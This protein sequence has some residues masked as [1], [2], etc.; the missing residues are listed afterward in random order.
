MRGPLR[1]LAAVL[2]AVLLPLALA[3]QTP[4]LS[5]VVLDA[6]TGDP[7]PGA[8][9][10]VWPAGT[11][12]T[13]LDG[14]FRLA[15]PA[16]EPGLDCRAQV[17]AVG[18]RIALVVWPAGEDLQLPK[19]IV[20]QPLAVEIGQAATV[21]AERE[22][23][24]GGAALGR[25]SLKAE[26][27]AR[28]PALLGE[29][30]ILKSLQL[31]PGIQSSGEGNSGFYIRGGGPDQN[32]LLL[33]GAPVY[34]PAHLF[35]F[36]SVFNADAVEAVDVTKGIPSAALGGRVSGFL[37][38]AMRAAES[39][40][41]R[42]EG[43]I[44]LISSRALVEGPIVPG[45]SGLLVAAR[46]TYVDALIRPFLR[47]G[48]FAGSGYFFHDLNLKAD[49]KLSDRDRLELT[50]YTG[51]DVFSFASG[52]AD[53][54]A[55]IPWGNSTASLV[56]KH[57]VGDRW[58]L[59]TTAA[60]T[61]YD[62]A[63]EADQ[64]LFRLALRSGIREGALRSA[65]TL[66]LRPGLTVQAGAE[67]IRRRFLPTEFEASSGEVD[68]DTGTA[69]PLHGLEGAAYLAADADFGPALRLAAGLRRSG[70]AHIGPFERYGT[71]YAAG[72][73]IARYGGWEPRLSARLRTG[74]RTSVKAGWGRTY[75][76]VH[77]ASLS[78]TSLPA[79]LWL[80]CTDLLA[81]Q[82]GDQL[83]AGFF[84]LLGP[85]DA[86]E[87]SVEAYAKDLRNLVEYRENVRPEDNI[88][89]P[90]DQN[91]IQGSG[92]SRGLETFLKRRSGPLTGW[93]G[94]TWSKTDRT[95]DALNGGNPFPARYDRRHDAS[96]VLQWSPSP[97]WD[98]GLTW[99]YATGNA[100]TLPVA[101]YLFEGRVTD[102]YGPRNGYRMA[103]YHRLDL[104]ATLHPSPRSS[105]TFG[106]Y[107]AYNRLNP[108]FIY[109]GNSGDPATG[110]LDIAAYQVS[111]FPVLPSV[112]YNFRF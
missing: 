93:I 70:F 101:R 89:V 96:F 11:A 68:F 10:Q 39:D 61:A 82:R 9:V 34:N 71:P 110:T 20:L 80:P 51:R 12:A 95:F 90:V 105:W 81:P 19:R 83:T 100:I 58:F 24:L 50:G 1:T 49:L 107:N 27:I 108:Y 3:G 4:T 76:Y 67:G 103:P 66:Y 79:D 22:A 57:T 91:L 54:A 30:D 64:D 109:F 37:D 62:F 21:E 29:V 43:G 65:L 35:G 40:R 41:F 94:Y 87:F 111:L 88:G 8:V 13:D 42:G 106:V 28:L 45:R 104:A 47:D 98:F 48:A 17:S 14:A 78:P 36:F 6:S 32:L 55:K 7:I 77:L 75:Q 15:L 112:S 85:S 53:F 33:D 26:E 84:A 102:V 92:T 97:R 16:Y 74:E 86:W 46:R 5:G 38:I 31:L 44:G 72:D 59:R 2:A 60:F 63:F 73:V 99:V 25:T 18:Y 56:W 69:L 23:A 52:T